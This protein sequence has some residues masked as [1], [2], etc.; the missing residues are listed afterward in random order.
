MIK[1]IKKWLWTAL[2][3][4]TLSVLSLAPIPDNPPLE[5]VPLIDKWVHFV[6]YGGVV[7][8]AWLDRYLNRSKTH[9]LAFAATIFLYAAFFGGLMELLQSL[10]GYRSGEWLDFV[11]D[12]L[13]ALLA[14]FICLPL[15][16]L[17]PSKA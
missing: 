17:F 8:A 11:A 15:S 13:G 1:L 6:M 3:T 7:C 9:P 4:I 14:I 16:K 2:A 12:S 10:T 5:D